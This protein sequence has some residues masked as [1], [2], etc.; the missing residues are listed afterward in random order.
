MFSLRLKDYGFLPMYIKNQDGFEFLSSLLS[1]NTNCVSVEDLVGQKG[2][3]CLTG[4]ESIFY[5]K[6]R[7][8]NREKIRKLK[9]IFKDDL[10]I[11]IQDLSL[12]HLFSM[13]T[14]E[15]IPIVCTSNVYFLKPEDSEYLYVFKIIERKKN[16]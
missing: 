4:N 7:E 8:N 3:I 12:S 13:A 6:K 14:E 9:N 10:Y 5:E 11:E 2:L 1:R 16:L 15:D